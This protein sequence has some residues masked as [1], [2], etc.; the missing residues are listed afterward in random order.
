MKFKIFPA[1]AQE[2]LTQYH[3]AKI[4]TMLIYKKGELEMTYEGEKEIL[5]A[6]KKLSLDL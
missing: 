6:V 4:P 3:V 1:K 5:D 2:D